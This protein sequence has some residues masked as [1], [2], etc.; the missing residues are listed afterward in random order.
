MPGKKGA[1]KRSE[2]GCHEI[3]QKN[4]CYGSFM[5]TPLEGLRP[6]VKIYG[7]AQN[8]LNQLK[9]KG[10]DTSLFTGRINLHL[11]GMVFAMLL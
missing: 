5:F 6:R 3:V 9:L 7:D 10:F 1:C 11:A 4:I 2:Q 8:A